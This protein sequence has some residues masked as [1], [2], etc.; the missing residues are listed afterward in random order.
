[1][2]QDDDYSLHSYNYTNA[3][4]IDDNISNH[5]FAFNS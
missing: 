4:V 3:C 2:D 1:M 5:F